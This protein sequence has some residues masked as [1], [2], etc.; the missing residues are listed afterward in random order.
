[1]ILLGP[2]HRVAVRGLALPDCEAFATP[3]GKVR[4]D[5]AARALIVQ[6]PQVGVSA[7]AHAQEHSLEV[8]LPFLQ[9]ARVDVTLLPLAVGDTTP[10]AVADVLE[11]LGGGPETEKR[12]HQD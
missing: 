4:L 9:R 8:H 5:A 6:L 11:R 10:E 12:D 7:A 1:M 3:L 2:T